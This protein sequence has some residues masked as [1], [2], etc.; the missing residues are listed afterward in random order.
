MTV[1][2]VSL[3]ERKPSPYANSTP[4]ERLVAAL[5]LIS[6]HQALRGGLSK[7]PRAEWPGETF[8]SP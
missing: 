1:E 4:E 3:G 8:R 7:L 5:R 2:V 6:Y